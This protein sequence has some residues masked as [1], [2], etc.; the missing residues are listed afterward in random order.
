MIRSNSARYLRKRILAA[1]RRT[2]QIDAAW[3]I[4]TTLWERQFSNFYQALDGFQ[5]SNLAVPLVVSIRETIRKRLLDLIRK[6]YTTIH[7]TDAAKYFG[8]PEDEVVPALMNEGWE[9]NGE[10]GILAASKSGKRRADLD[11]FSKLA[12]V[13]LQLENH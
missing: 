9:Y 5:W 11:Q 7:K 1:S 3:R 2:D 10:S 12:D 8:M 6:A 13:L 4:C